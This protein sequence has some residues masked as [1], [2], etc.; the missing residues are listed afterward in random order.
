MIFCLENGMRPARLLTISVLIAG[1]PL[2]AVSAQSDRARSP[3][4]QV[5]LPPNPALPDSPGRTLLPDPPLLSGRHRD[6]DYWRQF[7]PRDDVYHAWSW[8]ATYLTGFIGVNLGPLDTPFS[9][10]PE[11]LRL[12]CVWNSPH[13]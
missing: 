5:L 2:S 4:E 10:V 3:S 12:N 13:P 1:L 6:D 9:M 7:T 11:I 8:S